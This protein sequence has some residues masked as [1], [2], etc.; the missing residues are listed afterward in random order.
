MAN[1]TLSSAARAALLESLE[2]ELESPTIREFKPKNIS[3]K[4]MQELFVGVPESVKVYARTLRDNGWRFYAVEQARGACYYSEKVITIPVWAILRRT[5]PYKTWYI[6]H[7]IAHAIAMARDNCGDHGP[8][9][10]KALQEIC[11]LDCVHH[12]LGYK[13]RLAKAAGIVDPA[14]HK[15]IDM[16][17]LLEL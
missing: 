12:E 3:T 6:S 14:S 13:P 9:F 7:E 2:L 15:P 10:M 11:P 17:K 4:G 5:V 16:F 8:D 1:K